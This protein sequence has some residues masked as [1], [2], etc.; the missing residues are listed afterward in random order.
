[1][2]STP[3][4]RLRLSICEVLS[5][6]AKRSVVSLHETILIRNGLYCGRKFQAEGFEVVWF[7]EEDEIKFFG[8]TGDLMQAGSA[9]SFLNSC[10]RSRQGS[11]VQTKAA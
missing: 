3:V 1:M 10:E 4:E 11:Q 9:I 7:V 6:F 2:T 5:Q 8:P